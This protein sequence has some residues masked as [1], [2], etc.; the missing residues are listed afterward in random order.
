MSQFEQDIRTSLNTIQTQLAAVQA[1]AD[2]ANASIARMGTTSKVAASGVGDIEKSMGKIT[3][4][5]TKAGG[6]IAGMI[7][8]LGGLAAFNPLALAAGAA[9]GGITAGVYSLIAALREANAEQEKLNAIVAA[10]PG[11][12]KEAGKALLMEADPNKMVHGVSADQMEKN[13]AEFK[14][15]APGVTLTSEQELQV[16]LGR[17]DMDPDKAR[18]LLA[19]E[20][21]TPQFQMAQ[22]GARLRA[23]KETEKSGREFRAMQLASGAPMSAEDRA[24]AVEENNPELKKSL[25][26]LNETL[27]KQ[28]I[29][30]EKMP[31]SSR[32]IKAG[33]SR[34]VIG[35]EFW[36]NA[37]GKNW[38]VEDAESAARETQ[39]KIQTM[40]NGYSQASY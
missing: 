3:T 11:Q 25:D 34:S 19:M 32:I 10:A 8:S 12:A 17:G 21:S 26:A 13:L 20:R 38:G 18:H 27:K 6:P 22:E 28:T 1:K 5:A 23:E 2:G 30:L 4:A 24:R 37:M 16:K 7:S 15:S 31:E 33:L 29:E 9:I 35:A 36:K 40:R 39:E 14:K